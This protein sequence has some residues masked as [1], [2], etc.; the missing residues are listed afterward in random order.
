MNEGL[1]IFLNIDKT[2]YVENEA[3]IQRID[4]LLLDTGIKYSGFNNIYSPVNI[5]DR[6]DAVFTA[7]GVLRETDWLKDKLA[8]VTI[9]N[10]VD[11]C[12][13]D[14]IR[15]DHMA[16]L[17]PAKLEYYE[18]YYQKSHTLAHG[19]VVDEHGQIRDGYA[20]YIIAKKYG[21]RPDIYEAFAE[22]PLKKIVRGQHVVKDGDTWKVKCD[23]YYTW[24]YSLKDPVV[25]GDILEVRSPKEKSYICVREINYIT[26]KEYCKEHRYVAK[27][28]FC[29]V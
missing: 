16:E 4:E 5:A 12:P 1:A 14:Q 23:K 22:Q 18:K 9:I 29:S 26:G 27:H 17:S 15:T 6:D 8:Y 24:N 10:R 2:K 28:I 20:S 13:L 3:L 21:L 25:H 11:A 19:I 7:C